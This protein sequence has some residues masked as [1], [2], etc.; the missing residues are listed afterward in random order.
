VQRELELKLV[1][2]VLRRTLEFAVGVV[3]RMQS[4]K[5]IL[6]VDVVAAAATSGAMRAAAAAVAV[7]AVVETDYFLLMVAADVGLFGQ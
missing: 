1:L 6:D 2:V 5:W 3:V 4:E 7:V